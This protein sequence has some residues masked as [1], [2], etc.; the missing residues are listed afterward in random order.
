MISSLLSPSYV[1]SARLFWPHNTESIS[2]FG[3]EKRQRAARL[4]RKIS[5]AEG[6]RQSTQRIH[7][8]IAQRQIED[9]HNCLHALNPGLIHTKRPA[10][11]SLRRRHEEDEDSRLEGFAPYTRVGENRI[12]NCLPPPQCILATDIW[13]SYAMSFRDE[14]ES[15]F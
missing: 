8:A 6:T 3:Q 14:D 12:R 4:E 9:G 15:G 5:Q 7:G 2:Q 1:G 11:S 10:G 13:R